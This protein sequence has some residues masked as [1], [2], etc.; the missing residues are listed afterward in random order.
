MPPSRHLTQEQASAALR[1]GK[2]VEQYLGTG[3]E[4]RSTLRWVTVSQ[5]D[6][7]FAVL[8]HHVFDE[9]DGEFFDIAELSP[10]DDEEY[11]GE[12]TV[13]G[14][15]TAPEDALAAASELAK[16]ERNRWVIE[17]MVGD[18]YADSRGADS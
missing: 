5:R 9:S 8:L 10:V 3:D 12:G 6:E 4:G 17:G 11:I 13:L 7:Q 18:E 2:G 14:S 15:Y 16:A 1:R